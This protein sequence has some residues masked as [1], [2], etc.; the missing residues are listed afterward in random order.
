[1]RSNVGRIPGNSAQLAKTHAKV[2]ALRRETV[3]REIFE[4]DPIDSKANHRVSSWSPI[5][6]ASVR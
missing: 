6:W 4:N 1:M 3:R 5:S 2:R